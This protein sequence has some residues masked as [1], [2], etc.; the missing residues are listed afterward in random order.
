MSRIAYVVAASAGLVLVAAG[1]A[2]PAELL[3][4]VA[5]EQFRADLERSDVDDL[6]DYLVHHASTAGT[7][8]WSPNENLKIDLTIGTITSTLEQ[9][10]AASVRTTRGGEGGFYMQAGASIETELSA[11][12]GLILDLSY[13][14]GRTE[15]EDGTESGDYDFGRWCF[16]AG[17]VFGNNPERARPY[18]AVAYNTYEAELSGTGWKADL[19]YDKRFC[20]V[21]GVRARSGTFA[22]VVEGMVGSE[23]GVRLAL[24][25]GF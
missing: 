1:S 12:G 6:N 10:D 17:Y 22:G 23:L 15:W 8:E 19:E 24:M 14:L 16:Q 21:G 9:T 13:S 18:V 7:L 2:R 25:F 11:G 5:M 3:G 20:F 4:G